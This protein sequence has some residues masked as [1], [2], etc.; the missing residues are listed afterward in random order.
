M[1]QTT[2]PAAQPLCHPPLSP[3]PSDPVNNPPPW[4]SPGLQQSPGRAGTGLLP[5]PT[6]PHCQS[7]RGPNQ[8]VPAVMHDG[9]RNNTTTAPPASGTPAHTHSPGVWPTLLTLCDQASCGL[10]GL[11]PPWPATANALPGHTRHWST[12][13]LAGSA[14]R[15]STTHSSISL[16]SIIHLKLGAPTGITLHQPSPSTL[17]TGSGGR[18]SDPWAH[19]HTLS[20]SLTHKVD[21]KA[22]TC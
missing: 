11:P 9:V 2:N 20:V 1:R 22:T 8:P 21:L 15:C 3:S 18:G 4:L 14:A 19:T 5:Q 7:H 13:L 17:H 10:P 6:Q 12:V 16:H